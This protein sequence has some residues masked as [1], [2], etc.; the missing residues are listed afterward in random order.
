GDVVSPLLFNIVMDAIMRKAFQNRCGVQYD[1]DHFITDLMF[2]DDSAILADDDAEAKD[3][4]CDIARIA[5]S[6]GLKI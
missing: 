6:Y 3:I 1:K 5:Q 2:T 4:L